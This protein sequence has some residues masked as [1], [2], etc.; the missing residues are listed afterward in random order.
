VLKW[1]IKTIFI[2]SSP[3]ALLIINVKILS[4]FQKKWCTFDKEKGH[5]KK[6]KGYPLSQFECF[7]HAKNIFDFCQALNMS[8]LQLIENIPKNFM[9]IQTIMLPK[10]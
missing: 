9:T 5:L 6:T 3:F 4:N 10:L 2:S 7:E 1:V 8:I